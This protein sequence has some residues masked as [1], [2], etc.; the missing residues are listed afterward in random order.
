M[1]R[2]PAWETVRLATEPG[3]PMTGVP[4]GAH[5][6]PRPGTLYYYTLL[7][8]GTAE[9]MTARPQAPQVTSRARACV[10]RD[11]EGLC[12]G[13]WPQ[14]MVTCWVR[15]RS[16]PE[17]AGGHRLHPPA[18]ASLLLF[19]CCPYAESHSPLSILA[20]LC[21]ISSQQWW[22]LYSHPQQPVT[23]GQASCH[24]PVTPAAAA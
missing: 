19:P 1:L 16:G 4:L 20:G 21:L 2:G 23:E 9:D 24:P 5:C 14:R 10:Q 8:Y 18:A 12:Q 13:E 22:W 15:R 7:L 6:D 3:R 11:T 17:W